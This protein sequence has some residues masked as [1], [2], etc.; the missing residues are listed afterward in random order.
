[1][2]PLTKSKA[3]LSLNVSAG[4]PKSGAVVSML[5]C[6]VPT[7]LSLPALSSVKNLIVLV[8]DTEIGPLYVCAVPELVGSVPS[9]VYLVKLMP[10]PVP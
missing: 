10:E 8:L 1:M 3:S 4:L 7:E 5:T 6:F 9:S 2:V